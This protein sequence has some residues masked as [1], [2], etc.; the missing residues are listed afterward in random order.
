MGT[1]RGRGGGGG[2]AGGR[3]S[4]VLEARALRETGVEAL[5]L[6]DDESEQRA[7][8]PQH[9]DGPAVWDRRQADVIHLET[10]HH[11]VSNT[12]TDTASLWN[13][14]GG[15]NIHR[16]STAVRSDWSLC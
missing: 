13:T 1:V 15:L 9:G 2:H 16:V 6:H 4:V 8:P 7:G 3:G 5:L 11:T 14:A 10:Q 12:A